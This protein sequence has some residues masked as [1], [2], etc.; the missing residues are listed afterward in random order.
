MNQDL[1]LGI[2]SL[3]AT[4]GGFWMARHISKEIRR[5]K[6]WPTAP[7]KILEHGVGEGIGI[8]TT[9][10]RATVKVRYTVDGKEYLGDQVHLIRGTGAGTEAQINKLFASLPDPV[11]VHYNPTNPADS[12]LIVNP[13]WIPWL[14]YGAS[15][16][17]LLVGLVW[18]AAAFGGKTSP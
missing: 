16:I 2:L 12:Y 13:L 4:G 7:G 18:L 10:Y 1:L 14:I 11:P 6:G 3:I 5:K 17:F 15:T 9:S 8:R